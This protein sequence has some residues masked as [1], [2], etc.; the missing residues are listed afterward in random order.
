M[1]LGLKSSY[2]AKASLF[3]F[4]LGIVIRGFGGIPVDRSSSSG[5]VTQMT[6]LFHNTP[7]LVLGIA[8]EGTRQKVHRWRSGFALI[9]QAANVPV[10]PA[11]IDYKQKVVTF[12]PLIVDVSDPEQTLQ[13]VQQDAAAGQPRQG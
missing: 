10:Q 1:S 12:T 5:V 6:H 9:A 13:Q 2:L 11:V 8:P 4:P 7:K 3:R